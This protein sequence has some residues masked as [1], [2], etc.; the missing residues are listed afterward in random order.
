V[1]YCSPGRKAIKIAATESRQS[2]RIC[3]GTAAQTIVFLLTAFSVWTQFTVQTG[4][5]SELPR[6]IPLVTRV[7][8][9]S[10]HAWDPMASSSVNFCRKT[11][12]VPAVFGQILPG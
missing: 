10:E 5:K 12:T 1:P 4:K 2:V 11:R 8:A 7:F 6:G 9:S 3:P